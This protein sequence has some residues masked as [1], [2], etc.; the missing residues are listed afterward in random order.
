MWTSILLKS[1]ASLP[2]FHFLLNCCKF[3][4]Y[5]VHLTLGLGYDKHTSFKGETVL[6]SGMSESL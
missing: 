4:M 6:A 1:I 2:G 5:L 3:Y